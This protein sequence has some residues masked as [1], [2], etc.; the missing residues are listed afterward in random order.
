[1]AQWIGWSH[2]G[3]LQRTQPLRRSS[4]NLRPAEM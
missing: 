2:G 3:I 1:V 4:L